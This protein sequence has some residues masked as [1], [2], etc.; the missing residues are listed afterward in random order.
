VAAAVVAVAM[1][2]A[3]NVAASRRQDRR[4]RL[5]ADRVDV[6]VAQVGGVADLG[7]F[8]LGTVVTNNADATVQVQQLRL[9]PPLYDV[10]STGLRLPVPGGTSMQINVNL[11]GRCPVPV[12][13][14]FRIVV[15][16]VPASGHRRMLTVD[17]EPG[18]VQ[19]LAH[20]ACG[21][22]PPFTAVHIS[23]RDVVST[24]YGVSFVLSLTNRSAGVMHLQSIA[25][26]GL[27]LAVRGGTP[28][29]V[30]PHRQV[31]LQLKAELPACSRLPPPPG[32]PGGLLFGLLRL[33]LLDSSGQVQ[34]APYPPDPADQLY[35]ALLELR[36][37]ICPPKRVTVRV[38]GQPPRA[39]VP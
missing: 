21:E 3:A 9:D 18:L 17:V 16:V 26:A 1:V 33:A 4:A 12:G 39:I 14:A 30:P 24:Q 20:R 32:T 19:E 38:P 36:S 25:S 37:R 5:A 28:V 35:P 7:E 10:L 6:T 31:V 23:V 22:I 8:R 11:Q 27:A 13:A 2:A 29:L 34:V 15:P